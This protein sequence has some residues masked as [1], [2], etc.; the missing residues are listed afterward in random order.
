MIDATYDEY[1]NHHTIYD[2]PEG[3]RLWLSR[4][5]S[6]FIFDRSGDDPLDCDDPPIRIPA[7]N[8]AILCS[9][10]GMRLTSIGDHHYPVRIDSKLAAYLT[11]ER[12]YTLQVVEE[13]D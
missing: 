5:G 10:D 13:E 3:H 2:E 6:L 1:V 7:R 12:G 9:G 4:A 11:N 8:G